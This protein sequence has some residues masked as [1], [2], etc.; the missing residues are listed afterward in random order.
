MYIFND[1]MFLQCAKLNK[2][3][4]TDFIFLSAVDNERKAVCGEIGNEHSDSMIA[5]EF[6]GN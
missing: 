6:P 2:N 5:R 3:I 4:V 1:R